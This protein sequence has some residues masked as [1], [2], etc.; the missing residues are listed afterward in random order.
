MSIGWGWKIALLYAGFV[1]IIITLVVA[2]SRQH[3]DLVSKDYYRDEIAYQGVINAGKN[4]AG[5]SMPTAIHANGTSITIDFPM[6]FKDMI[7]SG[8]VQFYSP[9]N[10]AWDH[11]YKIAA[12]GNSM[13]ISRKELHNTRYIV[14]INYIVDGTAYYQESEITLQN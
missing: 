4:Q 11:S 6:E 3:F 2:S 7:L 5:L 12:I 8:S 10:A 13:T 9:V 1:A 14:K